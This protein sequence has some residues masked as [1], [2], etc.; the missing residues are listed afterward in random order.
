MDA[1]PNPSEPIRYYPKPMSLP[2]KH[3]P[4]IVQNRISH[5]LALNNGAAPPLSSS[6][7]STFR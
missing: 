5:R 4:S 6:K 1:D 2:P 7:G 3:N